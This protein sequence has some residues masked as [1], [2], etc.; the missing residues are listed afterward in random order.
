[1]MNFAPLYKKK[2][3]QKIKGLNPSLWFKLNEGTGSTLRDN[4][5]TNTVT[6][7]GTTVLSSPTGLMSDSVAVATDGVTSYGTLA[8]APTF[9][10][11]THG[12]LFNMTGAGS[13]NYPVLFCQKVSAPYGGQLSMISWSLYS[14]LVLDCYW[15]STT[16]QAVS[17]CSAANPSGW[18]WLFV[19]YQPSPNTLRLYTG[20]NGTVAERAY[21]FQQT[22]GAGGADSPA[23]NHQL[24]SWHTPLPSYGWYGKLAEWVIWPKLLDLAEMQTLTRLAGV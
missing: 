7:A 2:L 1:M 8:N 3:N 10:G 13:T 11:T 14:A 21:G 18:Q 6:V 17:I 15:A 24:F 20:Q 9:K 16:G 12:Y 23:T 5:G 22:G 4:V 19:Q